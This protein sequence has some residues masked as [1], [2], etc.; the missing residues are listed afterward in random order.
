MMIVPYT[1]KLLM[2]KLEKTVLKSMWL[3]AL[4][5]DPYTT[6]FWLDGMVIHLHLTSSTLDSGN[7]FKEE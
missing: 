3:I 7:G 6:P 5:D 1:A 4:T 2:S